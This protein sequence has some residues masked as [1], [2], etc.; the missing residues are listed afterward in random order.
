[1]GRLWTDG[2]GERARVLV[3]GATG[4]TGR[5]VL[6][7]LRS[8]PVRIRATTRNDDNADLLEALGADDVRVCDFQVDGDAE[9][10]VEDCDAVVCTVGSTPGPGILWG[11]LVDG[12][13]VVNLVDAA[14]AAGVDRFVLVSSIGVGDSAPAMPFVMRLPLR[15]TGILGAKATGENHLRESQ[16][17]HTIFRPGGL[18]DGEATGDVV[19]GEGGPTVSGTIPRADLAR[20][21]VAALDTPGAEGRTFEVV[22]REGLRSEPTGVVDVDWADGEL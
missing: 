10:A 8:R 1:M 16:L 3:A 5:A 21:L 18:T 14:A 4:D 7:S 11:D 9:R 2:S 20:L 6:R 22:S 17:A 13:G 15:A 19:V 12:T